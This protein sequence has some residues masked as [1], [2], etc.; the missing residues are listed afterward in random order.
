MQLSII[1]PIYNVEACLSRCL[2]SVLAQTFQDFELIL[3]D[4]GS[5]DRC[6]EI[7]DEY[8][9]KEIRIVV[10]HQKNKGVSAARNAGLRVARGKY[11]GFVDP[12]DYIVPNYYEDLIS[13]VEKN[14]AQLGIVGAQLWQKD[15]MPT[16]SDYKT[17]VLIMNQKETAYEL[18]QIP[19]TIFGAVCNKLFL[20]ERIEELFDTS[21][22]ICEDNLFV[23]HYIMN[24]ECTVW[25][26]ASYY[27]VFD[28]DGSATKTN[29]I[30]FTESLLVRQHMCQLVRES[31]F[32]EVF[33]RAVNCFFDHCIRAL[34]KFGNQSEVKRKIKG[35]IFNNILW[36]LSNREISNKTKIAYLYK[37]IS[38]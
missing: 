38:A 36:L 21:L 33:D 28:R 16:A 13:E 17:D 30:G 4:D 3:V 32:P 35:L 18:F 9:E 12:D 15:K 7:I 24:I 34:F 5:P 29:G 6:G 27:Y 2:D 37:T 8:A 23:L 10:I 31:S 1:V 26:Q 19:P 22:R 14:N 25:L 20:R 11:V